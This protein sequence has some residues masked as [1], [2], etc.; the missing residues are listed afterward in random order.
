[1]FIPEKYKVVDGKE[2]ENGSVE[3]KCSICNTTYAVP[4]DIIKELG[5]VPVCENAGCKEAFE[6]AEAQLAAAKLKPDTGTAT[7][8]TGSDTATKASQV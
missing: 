6:K 4:A 7:S 1:M 8:D 3:V 2:P 5:T